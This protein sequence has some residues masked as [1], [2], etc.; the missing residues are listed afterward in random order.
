MRASCPAAIGSPAKIPSGLQATA[1]ALP[2]WLDKRKRQTWKLFF[3]Q[4]PARR[5]TQSRRPVTRKL[6]QPISTAPREIRPAG[7]SGRTLCNVCK[8]GSWVVSAV[9]GLVSQISGEKPQT[10]NF[11]R[12]LLSCSPLASLPASLHRRLLAHQGGFVFTTL[13]LPLLASFPSCSLPTANG[14][15]AFLHS[16]CR[17]GPALAAT[18]DF[19]WDPCR[20]FDD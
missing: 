14:G 7:A 8:H 9:G 5:T 10:Q 12:F 6:H 3:L 13:S 1:P 18:V 11:C 20:R 2:L 16:S 4:Q 19:R 15:E 17:H